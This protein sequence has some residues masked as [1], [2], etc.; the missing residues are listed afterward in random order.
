M[1][2]FDWVFRRKRDA[3]TPPAPPPAAPTAPASSDK[4]PS[5]NTTSGTPG[6]NAPRSSE[7]SEDQYAAND[8]LPISRQEIVDAAKKHGRLLAT[9]FQFGRQSIIPPA[10]DPRTE[11]ID[12]ALVTH[13]LLTPEE[14]NE[15]HRV[16]E[17]Y[18]QV[19]PTEQGIAAAAGLAGTAAV[20]AYRA[21]KEAEK[22]RKKKEAD[23][24]K[25]VRAEAVW[26]RRTTDIIFLG[27]GVSGRLHLRLSDEVRIA[28]LG[29][30]VMHTPGDVANALGLTVPRLRWL[31]FHTDVAT[32]THYVKF[33]V[34]KKSGG[35]RQLAAPHKSLKAAQHWILANV[36]N[37]LPVTEA[38]HG[39]VAD[40]GI[41]T[42]ANPHVGKA[43]VVNL[44][45][46]DFFP[47]IAF[48]R[49][50]SA[51]ERYGYSGCVATILAL[52]CTECP[53]AAVTYAGT[54]YEAATGPRGLPQGAPTSPGLSNQVARKLDKRLLGVATKLG[55]TYTRYADD[56]TFSGDADAAAKIGWLLAKVR[57]IAHEE[58][59]AVNEKKT[60]VM[61]RSAAQMVTGVVV[62]D[63]PSVCRDELR[64][65]RA[66]LH[67]AKSEGLDAQNREG[68]PNF[69]E[70]L[71]GKIAF[72]SMVRPDA[73]AKLKDQLDAVS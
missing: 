42:N 35:T 4:A 54:K 6:A 21:A 9:A 60:R 39:F 62:N 40:R 44:D 25:K 52:L 48:P 30:P 47:S 65:L 7:G 34:P 41:V 33:S 31:A 63:K 29:L 27:R 61:R 17:E 71:R 68:L 32:R 55:L 50:R 1:S 57:H 28:E 36:V 12:R 59:F 66:I 8:F 56:L 53:R 37:K 46:S 24:R 45:L 18:E 5:G 58:G 3:D 73:G 72:V 11:I 43:F 19:R 26:R 64:R 13:G 69:R 20:Q 16:G 2:L 38:A 22:E 49:V 10:S 67:R 70:W 51:F 14:L 23:L 15:I